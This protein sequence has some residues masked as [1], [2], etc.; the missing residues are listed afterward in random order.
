MLPSYR[1]LSIGVR[2]AIAFF[3]AALMTALLGAVAYT[4]LSSISEQWRTYESVTLAKLQ[5]LQHAKDVFG[6][7]VHNYKDYVL[8]GGDYRTKFLA[9]L[10]AI[11]QAAQTS[12]ELGTFGSGESDAVR[13]LTAATAGYRASLDKLDALVNSGASIEARDHVVSGADKPI[14]KAL[15][16]LIAIGRERTHEQG[17]NVTHL[18]SV[19]ESTII[20]VTIT[21]LAA[22][23]LLAFFI[24][25]DITLPIG[26]AVSAAEAVARGDLTQ[27]I[28]TD[29]ADETGRLLRA[30][31]DMNE[32]LLQVVG[33][34]RGGADTMATATSEIA[35]GN[36]DLSSRTEEQ[37]SSLQETASSMEELTA[38][39]RQNADN[40]HRGSTLATSAADVAHQGSAVVGKVVRTM[41]E[42]SE[43]S[44]RIS[45][46]TGVVEGIAF[47]TN[48]LALNAAVEAAR[49]GD[50][51]RGFAVVAGEVRNLAQR[52]G[53]AAKEIKELI[54][55]SVRKVQD[56][57]NLAS[58]AG[59]T[60]SE[61][62]R[63]VARVSDIMGEIAA[64]ST[65]QSRGIEQV[66]LAVS[67]MDQVTQQNA[68]LVEQAAAASASLQEQGRQ[69]S[70]VVAFFRLRSGTRLPIRRPAGPT[71]PALE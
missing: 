17:K 8:R 31:R 26:V 54:A 13:A 19:A 21:A 60:M 42:I 47:Q 12:L 69:L 11:D 52:S 68:A 37:A 27:D 4:R 1:D 43:S 7:A 62:T 64:A 39:V 55:A 14:G 51:G 29:R 15:D 67:Q 32:N 35:A 34:V 33:R 30:L 56:G 41:E 70:E 57:T 3:I 45:D 36:H 44:K 58:E 59:A 6:D 71:S 40:A 63:A 24:T 48:I 22:A 16:V 49:A 18:A 2:L 5:L 28:T 23:V 25:R 61:V 66:N 50:Q 65:E 20:A 10:D 46:I 9:N 53:S 38:T